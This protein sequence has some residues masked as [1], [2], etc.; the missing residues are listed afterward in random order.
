MNVKILIVDDHHLIADGIKSVLSSVPS[1]L[2]VHTAKDGLEAI[3]FCSEHS[4]D[5]I[6]MDITMPRMNGIEATTIITSRFPNIK[7]IALS[8]YDDVSNYNKM[9]KAGAMAYLLKT[10]DKEELVICINKVLQGESY[11]SNELAKAIVQKESVYSNEHI[12]AVHLSE[13]E[14]MVLKL[15]TRG[16]TNVEIGKEL[17]IS[18]R[19]VET[20]RKNIM[21]KVGSNNISGLMRYAFS[22]GLS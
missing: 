18:E 17:S 8:M 2:V 12:D 13:R 6:L 3:K 1:F 11:I 21:K 15:L 16:K 5:I 9:K 14:T 22:I 7:V 4:V 19:T 20:H 10:V